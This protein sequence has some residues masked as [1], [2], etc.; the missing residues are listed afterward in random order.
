MD[1]LNIANVAVLVVAVAHI[2]AGYKEMTD[3]PRMAKR[4]AGIPIEHG[5]ATKVIGWN[6][7]LYNLLFAAGLIIGVFGSLVG[8]AGSD[9]TTLT[10]FCLGALAAAGIGAFVSMGNVM[11]MAMQ[12][13][14]SGVALLLIWFT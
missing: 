4:L 13:G 1:W 14:L 8:L 9:A 12:T 2:Y 10:V 5:E 11:I 7:G 6:Q 3:W